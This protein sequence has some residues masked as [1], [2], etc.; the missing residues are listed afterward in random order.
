[1]GDS[2]DGFGKS[3]SKS[4]QSINNIIVLH[5]VTTASL[6]IFEVLIITGIG[7]FKVVHE[8]H[9]ELQV[10]INISSVKINKQLD[11]NFTPT[12]ATAHFQQEL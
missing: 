1:M 2:R 3:K 8:L 9:F 11:R 6:S 4:C 5:L 10:Q 12:I 7:V